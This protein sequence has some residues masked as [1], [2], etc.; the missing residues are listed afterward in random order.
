MLNSHQRLLW[1]L[2]I[3]N[4][5]ILF[6][7]VKE[8]IRL[9]FFLIPRI[10]KNQSHDTKNLYIWK[11]YH[12][13]DSNFCRFWPL[14]FMINGNMCTFYSSEVIWYM[15][16]FIRNII[17]YVFETFLESPLHFLKKN[18]KNYSSNLLKQEINFK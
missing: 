18:P 10:I 15:L 6:F 7:F 13:S 8:V 17:F 9:K 4:H 3:F 12:S 16:C 2:T 1:I 14:S 11:N 5:K